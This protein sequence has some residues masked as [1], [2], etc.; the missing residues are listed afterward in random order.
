M[1]PTANILIFVSLQSR[2]RVVNQFSEK[3]LWLQCWGKS[4]HSF[5]TTAAHFCRLW[6][7]QDQYFPF[8]YHRCRSRTLIRKLQY[9]QDFWSPI[10]RDLFGLYWR[11]LLRFIL[12][13]MSCSSTEWYSSSSS[14]YTGFLLLQSSAEFWLVFMSLYHEEHHY[15]Q[16]GER[17]EATHIVS[18][19]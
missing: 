7:N 10:F 8:F 2:G 16:H 12:L 11:T 9:A 1:V 15:Q 13:E 3:S 19:A 4:L 5:A 18:A 17:V 6:G 14:F